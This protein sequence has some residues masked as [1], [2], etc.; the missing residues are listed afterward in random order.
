[1]GQ[2]KKNTKILQDP[3]RGMMV[4]RDSPPSTVPESQKYVIRSPH[5]L[6]KFREKPAT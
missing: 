4:E 3:V 1:M 6:M 5:C 2:T